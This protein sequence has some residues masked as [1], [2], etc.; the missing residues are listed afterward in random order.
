MFI[1]IYIFVYI[2]ILSIYIY[3]YILYGYKE[4]WGLSVR[5]VAGGGGLFGSISG[6]LYEGLWFR[7]IIRY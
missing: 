4:T 2:Y 5:F 7:V 6:P 3:I 1:Y